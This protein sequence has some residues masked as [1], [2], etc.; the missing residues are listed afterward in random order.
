VTDADLALQA[1]G[2]DYVAFGY[3]TTTITVCDADRGRADE[4]GK[5]GRAGGEQPSASPPSASG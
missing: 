5:G 1:L 3:I 4:K 2:A